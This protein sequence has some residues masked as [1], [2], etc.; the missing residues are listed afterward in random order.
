MDLQ[1]D[2]LTQHV[3]DNS[4]FRN[5]SQVSNHSDNYAQN[6][7]FSQNITPTKSQDIPETKAEDTKLEEV[8]FVAPVTPSSCASGGNVDTCQLLPVG[9]GEVRG[10]PSENA[11]TDNP[12]SP[13]IQGE[14]PD[15]KTIIRKT[16]SQLSRKKKIKRVPLMTISNHAQPKW[17]EKTGDLNDIISPN[18]TIDVKSLDNIFSNRFE[19]KVNA[20]SDERC[21]T[22]GGMQD[23]LPKNFGDSYSNDRSVQEISAEPKVLT[24]DSGVITVVNDVLSHGNFCSSVAES[25]GQM[26]QNSPSVETFTSPKNAEVPVKRI[27]LTPVKLNGAKFD[28]VPILKKET[29]STLPVKR[30]LLTPVKNQNLPRNVSQNSQN[31]FHDHCVTDLKEDLSTELNNC[32]ISESL[33]N[34]LDDAT[35]SFGS[36][37]GEESLVHCLAEV[38]YCTTCKLNKIQ[39]FVFL[40][41]LL[42]RLNFPVLKFSL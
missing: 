14:N 20:I 29:S 1:I 31:H 28:S 15:Q 32:Q 37:G 23:V 8:G 2:D 33:S 24:R 12:P 35:N 42:L 7:A 36:R 19:N 39:R 16:S 30:V 11:V 10:D 21:E 41:V 13:S 3:K 34:S 40:R 6:L 22:F 9:I 4:P 26:L 17:T 27:L 38:S 5:N 18:E 25:S